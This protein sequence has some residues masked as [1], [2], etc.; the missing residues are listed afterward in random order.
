MFASL[1]GLI[2]ADPHDTD[3]GVVKLV[4]ILLE[5]SQLEVT[6][7]SPITSVKNQQDGFW[8]LLINWLS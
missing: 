4:Q 2:N 1:L 3:S 7:P 8:W 6:I 5:T